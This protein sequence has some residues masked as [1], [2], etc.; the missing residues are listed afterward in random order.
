[1]ISVFVRLSDPCMSLDQYNCIKNAYVHQDELVNCKTKFV[2]LKCFRHSSVSGAG[3]ANPSGAYE[4]IIDCVVWFMLLNLQFSV[5]CLRF[6]GGFARPF[7][8]IWNKIFIQP[9]GKYFTYSNQKCYFLLWLF[10]P[11]WTLIQ[12]FQVFHVNK[13]DTCFAVRVIS[14]K[15]MWPQSENT[16]KTRWRD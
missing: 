5:L 1:M 12:H 9:R 16:T 15:V 13:S 10:Q 7:C 8:F 6:T 2:Y 14:Q 4:F 3:I 11:R